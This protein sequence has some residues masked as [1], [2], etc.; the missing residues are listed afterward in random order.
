[1]LGA[2]V[3]I[4]PRDVKGLGLE[5]GGARWCWPAAGGGGVLGA[6]VYTAPGILRVLDWRREEQAGAGWLQEVEGFLAPLY[7]LPPW[8]VEGPG[9]EAE[10]AGW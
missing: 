3:H 5:A 1:M 8:D 7:M 6:L 4:A 9:L 10:G 2:L